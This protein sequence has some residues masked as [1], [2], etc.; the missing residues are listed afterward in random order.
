MTGILN[1][2]VKS[3]LF[4]F[5]A[6]CILGGAAIPAAAIIAYAPVYPLIFVFVLAIAL[7]LG[8]SLFV[9]KKGSAKF[10]MALAVATTVLSLLVAIPSTIAEKR[11]IT[12]CESR[13]TG[14]WAFF[15][16]GGATCAAPLESDTYHDYNVGH[17]WAP[18]FL[19]FMLIAL[20]NLGGLLYAPFWYWRHRSKAA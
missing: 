4:I 11:F 2:P 18:A 3:K 17:A 16:E 6:V 15:D 13:G 9:Y 20:V 8:L 7:P 12:E 10:F 19:L 5:L 14:Y 1:L